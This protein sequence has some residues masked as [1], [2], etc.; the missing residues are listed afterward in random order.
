MQIEVGSVVEGKV[1]GITAFGAF[2][3]F[4]EGKSGMVHISEVSSGFVKDI[5]EFLK[6]GQEVKC[7]VISISPEGKIS[8]SIRKA[9]D[10]P[11]EGRQDKDQQN[12]YR[13]KQQN[14]RNPAPKVWQGTKSTVPAGEKQSFED[15]MARFK[16]ISED[17]A[18]DLKRKDSKR[19]SA[20]YSRRGKN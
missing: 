14:N 15:M 4:D 1:T 17:K 20:G 13:P 19:G 3:D 8:L 18:S 7:K 10:A 2:V 5:N 6:I 12:Q 9:E 16:Q 11:S